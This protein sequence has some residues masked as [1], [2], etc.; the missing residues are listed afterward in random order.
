MRSPRN[1]VLGRSLA[2]WVVVTSVFF[3]TSQPL[4]A[5]AASA[6]QTP[7]SSADPATYLRRQVQVARSLVDAGPPA[8][9][10][11]AIDRVLSMLAT[12]RNPQAAPDVVAGALADTLG[13]L[14][15]AGQSDRAWGLYRASGAAI[16]R[17][18]PATG[19]AVASYRRTEARILDQAGDVRGAAAAL[20][21][22]LAA[23][24]S[25]RDDAP[26]AADLR[27]DLLTRRAAAH[28][29][30]GD[31]AGARTVL[32]AHPDAP[33][34]RDPARAPAS[35][36]QVAYLTVRALAAAL[37]G[38]AD[39]AAG[40]ALS[41]PLGFRP[42]PTDAARVAVY[43]AA[44]VALA[45]P[46]GPARQAGLAALGRQLR[47]AGGDPA[48]HRPGAFDQTLIALALT[49]A[50]AAQDRT[51]A[52]TTFGL[53]QLAGRAGPSFDADALTALGQA[54]TETA[55]RTTHQA[56]RLRARRDRLV[57]E[58]IQAV[59]ARAAAGPSAPAPL[60]HDS[61]ARGLIRDFDVRIAR[62]EAALAV[63][64]IRV[65][66][67]DLLPLA[68]LQAVLAEDEAVLAMAPTAGG[69]AYMCLRRG[70]TQQ[71]IGAADPARLRLDARLVQ[72]A[73]TATH[74]P[75]LALDRQYPV[76]AAMRLY[77]GLIRPFERCLRPRDRI[78]WL[79]GLAEA[80]TPLAALLPAPP[81]K[82]AGGYDLA[83]ADWL[84]RRHGISYAGSAAALVAA[85]SGRVQAAD[86]DFLGVGDPILGA[87]ATA[88][89]AQARRRGT[90][91]EALVPLPET[92]A[93]LEASASGFRSSRVLVQ[94]AAS[95]AGLRREM[96]G[97]YR[98]LAFA[99]HGLMREDLQGLSEPALVLTPVTQAD[100]FDDGLLTA[101]E[102]A[103]LNLRAAFVAL[104]ACNTANV[105]LT[106]LAQ[107]LPALASAFAV[108]GAPST[109]ATLWPVNS[110]TSQQVVSGVFDTLRQ[111]GAGPSAALADAQRR[112]LATPPTP[113]YLH[114]RF[115]AP[116]VILGDGGAASARADHGPALR[117]VELLT[118]AG[119]EVLGVRQTPAGVATSFISDADARGRQ[120]SAVR[121]ADT[122]GAEVWRRDDPA[123][124]AGAFVA[125]LGSRLMV[126]GYRTGPAGRFVP[127]LQAFERG[128]PSGVWQG[129][130]LARVDAFPMAGAV[131]GPDRAVLA[132]GELNLRDAPD[133]GGGRLHLLAVG[134]DLPPRPLFQIAAPP[135]VAIAA[136]TV[137]P[138][139][140]DLLITYATTTASPAAA[141]ATTVDDYDRIGCSPAQVTWLERRD[142]RTGALRQA[143]TIPGL[144][145]VAAQRQPDGEIRLGGSVR[146][147][148][149]GDR[150]ATVI[151]VNGRLAT[152]TLYT[153]VSL[154][155]SDVR[156]L[157]A[158]P[159]GG[160]F[161]AASKE[162]VVTYRPPAP[163]EAARTN[164]FAVMPFV[165]TYAGLVLTL[166]RDGTVA[167]PRMLDSG[168]NLYVTAAA[169]GAA[170]E[171]LLG[172]ALAGQAAIF[173]LRG[174]GAQ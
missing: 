44:G 124:G 36:A 139:G 116:F 75:N 10:D 29:L 13:I 6:P 11:D 131:I 171:I 18:L 69:Y 153:D 165:N 85:R 80:G 148:C 140:E 39:P 147:G 50:G 95:E 53:F 92:R 4:V 166:G 104:S 17:T 169:A 94:D 154:G 8:A 52:D 33:V 162:T 115:W 45:Q 114:P 20:D 16:A 127:T 126:S 23:L 136:V 96:V 35:A 79:S 86:F 27:A 76:A 173:H 99:T 123:T 42:T 110:Q 158:L 47:Q 138:M 34:F 61:A 30:A 144:A 157:A 128:V 151:A 109:L 93:E 146:S 2:G 159:G 38:G 9:R 56:L 129:D 161:V 37:D 118:R 97:S 82:V 132:V 15:D 121:V 12:I 113:A 54:P 25:L 90:R 21:A 160:T 167:T 62:A 107:D 119:G 41:R 164:P 73:L 163:A 68:R 149:A 87:T 24:A 142:A 55:R 122:A 63:D 14:V 40:A 26:G 150:Q 81:P 130:G 59:M 7:V 172:G 168:S 134:P 51:T 72:A 152:R 43:R 48:W 103:D 170:D 77:D 5:A 155:A 66:A 65:G 133:A 84:V 111:A 141:L 91:L 105:D 31:A 49:Q 70:G 156:T 32:A 46:P 143:R 1:S 67:P 125:Q 112:F 135:G 78:V 89:P 174:P 117:S 106:Q 100:P 102:I 71:T 64:R 137:T 145:V 88:D 98:Y 57:R 3:A 120:G 74:A 101:S 19:L 60:I 22:G 108:A 58:Q 83:A 28:V